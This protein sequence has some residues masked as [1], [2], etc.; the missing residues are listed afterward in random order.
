VKPYTCSASQVAT[1]ETCL[2]KWAAIKIGGLKPPPNKYAALGTEVHEILASWL[3]SARPPP[4]TR[5]GNIALA[6]LK[7]LPPPQTKNLL[8]ETEIEV[9]LG[10][11]KFVGF[12]DAA[13]YVGREVPFVADHKTTV[14][15]CWA[16]DPDDL[17]NDVQAIGRSG[18]KIDI[19]RHRTVQ[20]HAE[21]LADIPRHDFEFYW[22]VCDLSLRCPL[23]GQRPRTKSGASDSACCSRKASAADKR[24]ST[25]T[26]PWS[27]AS[28]ILSYGSPQIGQIS[29]SIFIGHLQGQWGRPWPRLHQ[30]STLMLTMTGPEERRISA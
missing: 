17:R 18:R 28:S 25:Q 4:E 19:W 24:S 6:M 8:V 29:T 9:P 14:D 20:S 1:A 2:R 23:A 30:L 15:F 27:A 11:V 7:H 22:R 3:S 13:I 21:D 12:V 26:C 10:G 5:A 16:K